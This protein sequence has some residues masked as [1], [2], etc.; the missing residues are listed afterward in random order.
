MHCP[1]ASRISLR[2]HP[3]DWRLQGVNPSNVFGHLFPKLA[4]RGD[5]RL[6]TELAGLRTGVFPWRAAAESNH[7]R[8]G[9]GIR[10][11]PCATTQTATLSRG[12][13]RRAS[14]AKCWGL[15]Q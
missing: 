6:R 1:H 11:A 13:S 4:M 15:G 3:H 7:T 10:P 9:F 12:A 8:S 14:Y 5:A 2:F